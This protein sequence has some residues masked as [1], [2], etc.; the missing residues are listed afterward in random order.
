MREVFSINF[1]VPNVFG[2]E[3][4]LTFAFT[5]PYTPFCRFLG[6]IVTFHTEERKGSPYAAGLFTGMKYRDCL[7]AGLYAAGEEL[8]IRYS[9]AAAEYIKGYKR[10]SVFEVVYGPVCK[11]YPFSGYPVTFV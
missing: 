2:Y 9:F 6:P 5:S 11:G 7:Y 8:F 1:V 4:E 3:L 10:G